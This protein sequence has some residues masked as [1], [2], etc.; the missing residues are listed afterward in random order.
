MIGVDSVSRLN[1]V[2]NMP[3]TR[4]YLLRHLD[5]IEL[6][7]YNKV[8]DNTFVNIVPMTTGRLVEELPWNEQKSGEPFDPYN[9]IWKNFSSSGYFTLYA[10]DDPRL[11]IFNYIKRGFRVPPADHYY[12]PFALAL[13]GDN[14]VWT[15]DHHCVGDRFETDM[16]LNY[17]K[18]LMK[19][20]HRVPYFGF[21]F[22]S[23]LTHDSISNTASADTPYSNMFRDID[24]QGLL[25]NTVLIFFSDHG[26][27]FGEIR[28]TYIGKLEERLPMMFLVFP[29]WF[30]KK[31]PQI[32]QN[33]KINRNRLTTPFD[34]Y[35]TLKDILYFTGDVKGDVDVEQR[36]I[37]LFEE[38][39][40]SRSCDHAGILPHW[41]TCMSQ[42]EL[43]NNDQFYNMSVN[44]LI[45]YINQQFVLNNVTDMCWPLK[46]GR[47]KSVH[48]IQNNDKLLKYKQSLNDVI[49]RTVSFNA[50][51]V[52][53]TY[54]FQVAVSLMPGSGEFEASVR[55]DETT[56]NFT[57]AGDI[58][59]INK[60]GHDSD[61]V[62]GSLLHKLC[63]C[64]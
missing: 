16:I 57:M 64:K 32:T 31:Y 56:G 55:Y 12:R 46:L 13:E 61:C 18:D 8:A 41:C 48:V 52:L 9:F 63:F 40:V 28:E 39:P 6:Q 35:E 15:S 20:Y 2:R 60:Y 38:I 26:M 37:S 47:T 43:S 10:E 59:R 44:Y 58:S 30:Y 22:L 34:I 42:Q 36:G 19:L 29:K 51:R 5:A 45:T 27:R 24:N 53:S 33:L 49:N 50:K 1:H 62:H 25:N 17:T 4:D 21:N 11:G 3:T 54:I 23:R 7:G 14:S